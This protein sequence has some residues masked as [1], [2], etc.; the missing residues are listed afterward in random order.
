M[1]SNHASKLAIYFLIQTG[2]WLNYKLD[3]LLDGLEFKSQVNYGKWGNEEA[4]YR[5][6]FFVSTSQNNGVSYVENT[7]QNNFN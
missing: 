1:Y 7:V 4:V 6:V 5:P 2:A 3:F